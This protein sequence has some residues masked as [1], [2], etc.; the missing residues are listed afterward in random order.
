MVFANV[1]VT[2]FFPHDDSVNRQ[3]K[4]IFMIFGSFV[5]FIKSLYFNYKLWFFKP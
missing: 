3:C 2:S 4:H 1:T 5:K